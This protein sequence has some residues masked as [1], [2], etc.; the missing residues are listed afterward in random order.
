[1]LGNPSS[2]SAAPFAAARQ[3][4]P[5]VDEMFDGSGE[6]EIGGASEETTAPVQGGQRAAAALLNDL[7]SSE[8]TVHGDF[9]NTFGID[10]FDDQ[11]LE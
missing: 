7:T 10:Y 4:S 6:M 2:S 8:R 5:M 11:D 1:M 9:T 3:D